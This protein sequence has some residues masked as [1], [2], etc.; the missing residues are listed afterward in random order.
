VRIRLIRPD[1]T[2]RLVELFHRLSSRSVF[3]RF[4]HTKQRLTDGDL[5]ELTDLDFDHKAALAATVLE[6]GEE[7]I[8]GVIRYSV[9]A[10]SPACRRRAEVSFTV[11]D[12]H[13]G[14]G[15][16]KLLLRHLV[17]FARCL[18]IAE[19]E[20]YVLPENKQMLGLFAASDFEVKR[21]FES[22]VF[23]IWFPIGD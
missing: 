1:D 21:S 22:G 12:E 5:A 3:F 20:A 14:R 17:L 18:G 8:I 13:Q 23:H 16:G 15:I 9:V 10:E 2:E 6:G 19:F 7:R 11:R 4:F